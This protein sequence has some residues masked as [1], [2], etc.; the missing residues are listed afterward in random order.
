M[1]RG[2]KWLLNS[3]FFFLWWVFVF[4]SCKGII[5]GLRHMQ[6]A[7]QHACCVQHK[8]LRT[9]MQW[10]FQVHLEVFGGAIFEWFGVA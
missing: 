8:P 7:L 6:R 3:E 2:F 10:C 4:L 1:D 9:M 5:L